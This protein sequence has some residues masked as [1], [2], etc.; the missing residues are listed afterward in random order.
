MDEPGQLTN[1]VSLPV[2]AAFS[3]PGF[4]TG[5]MQVPSYF[6]RMRNLRV[7]RRCLGMYLFQS[8]R[9]WSHLPASLRSLS[10]GK[11]YGRHLHALV[12]LLAERKQYFAT[13]FLRN[14]PELE[15]M[16]RLLDQKAH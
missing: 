4:L 13:F 10:A 14:R 12:R 6:G 5:M 7:I 2:V 8:R 3:E 16:R 11:L 15:L 9:V 1:Q